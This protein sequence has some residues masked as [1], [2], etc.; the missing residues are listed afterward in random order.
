MQYFKNNIEKEGKDKSKVQYLLKGKQEFKSRTWLEYMNK[1][2]RNQTNHQGLEKLQTGQR[3]LIGRVCR[4]EVETQQQ[5]V[6]EWAE[7]HQDRSTEVT[8]DDI[9]KENVY[10]LKEIAKKL[11]TTMDKLTQI[12]AWALYEATMWQGYMH[13]ER[14]C[15]VCISLPHG[16]T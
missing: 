15:V 10:H 12:K 4:T 16:H 6:E 14:I 1:C 9:F 11:Q 8:K 7:L 3:N 13:K 2:T 5:I